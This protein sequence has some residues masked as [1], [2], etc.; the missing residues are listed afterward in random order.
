MATSASYVTDIIG[1][2]VAT[3]TLQRPDVHNAFDDKMIQRLTLEFAGLSRS[4]AVRVV[5]IAAEGKSFCA[6]ADLN[7]MQRSAEYDYDENL[8]DAQALARMM[9]T[10]FDLH[11]PT[12][13]AVQGNAFGG[14]VGLLSVC[15]VVIAEEHAEFA[16]TEV[17]L[18]IIPAVISPYVFNAIGPRQARRYMLS[19]ERFD[20]RTAKE[21]GLVHEVVPSGEAPGRAREF[22]RMM[23][24][25]SPKALSEAKN[26][27]RYV[28]GHPINEN[29]VA[30]TAG[31]V[32]RVRSSPEGKEGLA[33]FLEKR[34][35]N[36]VKS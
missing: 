19:A 15:D 14:G 10:I 32:A 27:A 33:A 4:P 36:W 21:I 25:N 16:L 28:S 26:L 5:V 22:A 30:Q 29:I 12:V 31:H 8:A 9:K 35:P 34:N 6:G 11:K 17:R 3:V 7:W 23:L 13:A 18:G 2:G 1:N 20:A 24:G